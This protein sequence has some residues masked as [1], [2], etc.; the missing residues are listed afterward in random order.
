MDHFKSIN[1]NYGHPAGDAAL[2]GAAELI[3]SAVRTADIAC[4][5]GGEEFAV[6]MPETPPDK[7]QAL[8]D[9]IRESIGARDWPSHPDRKI[10]VSIGVCGSEGSAGLTPQ[11]W[12]AHADAALYRSKEGGRTRVVVTKVG[13]DGPKLAAAS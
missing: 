3:A 7:A 13:K 11:Q 8:C 9:R 12:L 5:Y 4:R 2:Q 1:D 6:L 10:T